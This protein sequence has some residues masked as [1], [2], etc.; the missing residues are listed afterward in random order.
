[1]ER[2]HST[3]F[4]SHTIHLV[5][6]QQGYSGKQSELP[7]QAGALQPFHFLLSQGRLCSALEAQ[8]ALV[9]LISHLAHLEGG[10]IALLAEVLNSID[11]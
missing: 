2:T 9:L 6:L 1:M 11:I 4:L 7:T 8:Q 10:G 3:Y 5:K